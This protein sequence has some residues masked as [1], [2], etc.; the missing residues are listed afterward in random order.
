MGAYY[1]GIDIGTYSSKGV[2]VDE[3]GNVVV[4]HD[5]AHSLSIPHDGWAEHD[6]KQVW[7][8]EFV[9]ICQAL[10]RKSKL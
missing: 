8:G 7:W 2:I 9:E 4:S 1:L 3:Q 5:I 6:A 10:L